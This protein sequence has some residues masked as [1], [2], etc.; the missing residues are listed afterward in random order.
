MQY[1]IVLDVSSM[2]LDVFSLE[3]SMCSAC[4]RLVLD[5]FGPSE[6]SETQNLQFLLCLPPLSPNCSLFFV[7]SKLN[8]LFSCPFLLYSCPFLLY[9]YVF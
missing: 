1:S 5:V 4:A 3:C 2:V 8:L 6:R 7:S 9:S